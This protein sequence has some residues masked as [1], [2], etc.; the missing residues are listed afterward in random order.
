MT[1]YHGAKWK[2]PF[3]GACGGVSIRRP[4]RFQAWEGI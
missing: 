4:G 2:I 1:E 3:L